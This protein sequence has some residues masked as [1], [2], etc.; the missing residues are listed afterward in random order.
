[1]FFL[2]LFVVACSRYETPELPNLDKESFSTEEILRK[3]REIKELI[4]AN[5]DEV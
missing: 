2:I 3:Q 5:A 1:M 4:R